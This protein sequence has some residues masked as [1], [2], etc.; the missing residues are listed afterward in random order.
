MELL[1]LVQASFVSELRHPRQSL[2]GTRQMAEW[3]AAML[4]LLAERD[5][6]PQF[7]PSSGFGR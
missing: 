3:A 1:T 6:A 4:E 5:T 7:K 2:D